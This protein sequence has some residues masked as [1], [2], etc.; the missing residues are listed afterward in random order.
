MGL[1]NLHVYLTRSEVMQIPLVQGSHLRMP[2]LPSSPPTTAGLH[3]QGAEPGLSL[4]SP[5][6]WL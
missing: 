1:E 4:L 3:F 6:A 5:V 2:A